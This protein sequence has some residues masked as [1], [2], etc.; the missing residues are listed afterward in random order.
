MPRRFSERGP[1]ENPQNRAEAVRPAVEALGGTLENWW[2]TL[3]G[4]EAVVIVSMPDDVSV[5]AFTMALMGGGA[6]RNLRTTQLLDS[7]EY[8]KAMNMAGDTG[9][10]IPW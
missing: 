4:Y 7:D 1:F 3:G 8:I 5:A 9:Y 6:V 2:M 10:E